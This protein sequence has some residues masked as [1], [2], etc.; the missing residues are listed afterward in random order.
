MP[1]IREVKHGP[2]LRVR[3][4]LRYLEEWEI[5]LV[6]RG[7]RE[8]VNRREDA[9]VRDSPFE[10]ARGFAADDLRGRRGGMARV[11][12]GPFTIPSVLPRGEKLGYTEV[13]LWRRSQEVILCILECAR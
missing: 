1:G 9:G 12:R 4:G 5:A 2:K 3:V 11:G 7:E 8:L 6:R 10:I 13:A